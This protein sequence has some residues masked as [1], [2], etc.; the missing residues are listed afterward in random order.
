MASCALLMD[1]AMPSTMASIPDE[2]T[3]RPYDLVCP[4]DGLH[5]AVPY[6][7]PYLM[8]ILPGCMASCALL[9]DS[10]MPSN[11]AS[12]PDEDTPRLYGLVCPPDGLHDAVHHGFRT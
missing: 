1:S 9:M 7:F 3:P 5:D 2:D 11:M 12:I 4:T 8:K 6:G 10:A